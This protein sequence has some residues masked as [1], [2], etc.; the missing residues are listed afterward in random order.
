MYYFKGVRGKLYPIMAL[1][2]KN[3]RISLYARTGR[4]SIDRIGSIIEQHIDNKNI[5]AAAKTLNEY[6]YAVE[7]AHIEQLNNIKNWQQLINNIQA[8]ELEIQ[9]YKEDLLK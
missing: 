6:K 2:H 9:R 5:K 4:I 1:S 8:E 3:K 7:T